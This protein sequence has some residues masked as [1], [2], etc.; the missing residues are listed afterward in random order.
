MKRI[1]LLLAAFL[2]LAPV[3]SSAGFPQRKSRKQLERE[4]EQLRQRL[5]DEVSRIHAIRYPYN[6]F[7]Y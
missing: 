2:V 5:Y 4:N 6:N 3:Q 1:L 7:L